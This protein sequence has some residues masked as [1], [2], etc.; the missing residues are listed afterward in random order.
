MPKAS[1]GKLV[2]IGGSVQLT[3]RV[4]GAIVVSHFCVHG[5]GLTLVERR[6]RTHSNWRLRWVATDGTS[7]MEFPQDDC[8]CGTSVFGRRVGERRV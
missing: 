8:P 1:F 7:R 3:V 6:G 4:R 2:P 5:W